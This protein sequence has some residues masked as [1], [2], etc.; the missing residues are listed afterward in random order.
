MSFSSEVKKEL[1]AYQDSARHCRIAFLAALFHISPVLEETEAGLITENKYAAHAFESV[2][3][4][5]FSGTVNAAQQKQGRSVLYRTVLE[6]KEET[7]RFL[8]AVKMDRAG[9]DPAKIREMALP[10][11]LLQKTCCR[12][13]FLR[14]VFLIA[15]SVSDPS[16]SYHFELSCAREE[17]ASGL[18]ALMESLGFGA[19]VSTRKNRFVVYLKEGEQ[20]SDVLGAMGA[21]GSLMKLENARILRDIAGKINRQ[22]N[23]ET[24]NLMK[25]VDAALRE[26]EDI[27]YLQETV[28]LESL[29]RSLRSAAELR[30]AL[31]EASL[32]ELAQASD[33]PVGRSG[34]HHRLKRLA[35]MADKLRM[36]KGEIR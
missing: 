18:A 29:P 9:R 25:T 30:L 15:G 19:K 32:Q 35:E 21:T 11:M 36:E 27:R 7:E 10:S 23:F 4:K 22:V 3:R 8:A 16:K 28:G 33:P 5:T 2:L 31:P 24:A 17:D 34:I 6:G 1:S 14:G 26:Q 12:K 13:A 20:I